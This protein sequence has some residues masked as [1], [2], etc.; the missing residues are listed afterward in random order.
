VQVTKQVA[1][2]RSCGILVRYILKV[3][4]VIKVIVE[5]A[6]KADED[7]EWE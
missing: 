3:V 6:D 4:V 7:G 1:T 2:S 5:A